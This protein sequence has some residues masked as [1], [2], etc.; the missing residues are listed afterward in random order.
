MVGQS[1]IVPSRCRL[2]LP[3]LHTQK[4]WWGSVGISPAEPH[5]RRGWAPKYPRKGEARKRWIFG[6]ISCFP[7][8]VVSD[9]VPAGETKLHTE[10][11]ES[12]AKIAFT[13]PIDS[14]LFRKP[15]STFPGSGL[16]RSS[17]SSRSGWTSHLHRLQTQSGAR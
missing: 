3:H 11:A 10:A 5:L 1:G 4:T 14:R 7:A 17:R 15:F 16:R 8:Q 6:G 9:H 13:P 2:E 12:H